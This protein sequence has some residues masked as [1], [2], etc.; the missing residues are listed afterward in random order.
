MNK[1]LILIAVIVA[2]I[3]GMLVS[4]QWMGTEHGMSVYALLKRPDVVEKTVEVEVLKV[5]VISDDHTIDI[6]NQ[7][8]RDALLKIS[9]IDHNTANGAQKARQYAEDALALPK[10]LVKKESSE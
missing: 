4:V 2:F 8:Y 9:T 3:S 5:K 7:E 1:L 6:I 10:T